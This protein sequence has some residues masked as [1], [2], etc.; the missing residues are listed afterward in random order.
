M[1]NLICEGTQTNY[2]EAFIAFFVVMTIIGFVLIMVDKKRWKAH[3]SRSEEMIAIR[4]GKRT[5]S[6][7][8][9]ENNDSEENADIKG[10]KKKKKSS[11]SKYEYAGRIKDRVL[12]PFAILFG[13]IGE[14][15][16]M[17]I[18]RHKWYNPVYK[19]GMPI[20]A[21]INLAFMII[22]TFAFLGVSGNGFHFNM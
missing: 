19:I 1:I 6:Q 21:A 15:L 2:V 10:K 9:E 17:I 11:D 5:P 12:I 20:I 14:L 7:T 22:I 13:G 18:F 8:E 4:E 16:G 3:V